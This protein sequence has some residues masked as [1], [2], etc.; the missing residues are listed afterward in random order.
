[1]YHMIVCRRTDSDNEAFRRLVAELDADLQIR[2]GADN[3][4]YSQFNK[5]DTIK[6]A[7]VA[8]EDALPVGC[9]AIKAYAPGI[10]EV[11][12]MYVLP[13]M[14]GKGIAMA[15]LETLESWAKELQYTSCILETGTR[16][17]EAISLY[18]KSGYDRIPNYGQ[19]EGVVNSVC[20]QKK[21]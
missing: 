11:K 1:M 7:I 15:I 5:I 12:R 2:D 17:P 18:H 6:H 8:Y 13:A 14:R 16:Q 21:L 4:F 3:A 20:F 19:Y 10:A 9:G